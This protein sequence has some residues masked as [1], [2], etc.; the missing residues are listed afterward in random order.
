MRDRISARSAFFGEMLDCYW[1]ASI[2][3]GIVAAVGLFFSPE[4]TYWVALP[5]A[6]SA[7]AGFL[8]RIG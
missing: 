4:V 5:F 3:V 1:C 8:S 6:L 2:W 7:V